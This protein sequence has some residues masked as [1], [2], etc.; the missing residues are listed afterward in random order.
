[1]ILYNS[2]L[3]ELS[4]IKNLRIELFFSLLIVVM[5]LAPISLDFHI[6]SYLYDFIQIDT[7]SVVV[8]E[9]AQYYFLREKMVTGPVGFFPMIIN[10]NTE[11]VIL[12]RI[13]EQITNLGS[14]SWYLFFLGFV[15]V[16]SFI[17]KI[18]NFFNSLIRKKI[19]ESAKFSLFYILLTGF[20]TQILK[21]I[22]GR[23]RPNYTNFQESFNFDFLTTDSHLHSFPSGHSS[24]IFCVAIVL[25]VLFPKIKYFFYVSAL[26]ISISRLL[27]GAHFFT[28]ILGGF[29]VA[30]IAYKALKHLQTLFKGFNFGKVEKINF[31]ENG[32]LYN[33]LILF[34]FIGVSVSVSPLIDMI[35][36][37]FFYIGESQFFL[38]K[39]S[40]VTVFFR[41]IYL[42][43]ILFYVLILT[44]FSRFY[45]IKKLFFN[46]VFYFKEVVF[47]WVSS[48]LS[49]L[50]VVNF[51]FKDLWGRSRPNDLV[52]FDGDFLFT[53]WFTPS[54][55]CNSNC[56][57]VSGDASV[58]YLVVV[59]FFLTKNI[60]FFYIALF[61]GVFLGL[62]RIAEG[63][64]F[65]SDII[66]AQL[67]VTGS[68]FFFY[69]LYKKVYDK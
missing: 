29:V 8:H 12:K 63:G 66:F 17:L 64:H 42:P 57:F 67:I 4:V 32:V 2:L 19:L 23:A 43:L 9:N 34:V 38:Q 69:Y 48:A 68:L 14:S 58:G 51:L 36:S 60:S 37:N 39:T 61:S 28:D 45:F 26:F 65:F 15:F 40:Y 62:I 41:K 59:L 46:K 18:F 20:I 22:F 56:S 6:Y 47:I 33:T 35:I 10:I 24:T 5:I 54:N 21:F 13:F 11:Q 16:L 27:V 1:M 30:L 44:I 31:L 25:G 7:R 52:F 49:M 53:A 3:N 50:L 55:F